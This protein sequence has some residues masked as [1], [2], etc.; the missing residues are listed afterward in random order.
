MDAR[1][2]IYT[3]ATAHLDTSW[4][5][6]LEQ[7][8]EEYI[9][10]TLEENFA[11]FEKFPEYV[12]SFEGAYRYELMEEYYPALFARL[13][14]YAAAGRWRVAG[15][16]YE[17]GDVNIPAPEAL[18]RNFLLGQRYFRETFGQDSR[19]VFLPDCFGFG[20]ALPT[21]AA[22]ANLLGFT[23]Q[24]LEWGGAH[25]APFALGRW[26]GPDG[27]G[28]F[29]APDGHNYAAS[30]T[31]IRSRG[32]LRRALAFLRRRESFPAALIL[33]GV[34]DQGG[35][36]KEASVIRVAEEAE[37]NDLYDVQVLSAGSDQIFRDLAA[38]PRAQ[39]DALPR[40]DG[41][42]L[43]TNHGSGCYTARTLSKRWNRQAEQL[44]DAAERAC[45][46]ARFLGWERYPQRALRAAWKR[47][48][49]HQFHD[50]MTGTSNEANYRRNWNDLMLSQQ[51]FA[52]EYRA[53]VSAVCGGMDM[54][55]AVGHC[56]AVANPL[57]W[58]RT[59]A[60]AVDLPELLR[61][62]P[63]C[64]WDAAGREYPAQ[65]SADGT[66]AVFL[67]AVPG[68][69]V[70]LFDLQRTDPLHAPASWTDRLRAGLDLT[71]QEHAL[72]NKRLRVTIND[73]GDI[74]S[75][76]DKT[77][78]TEMLKKPVRLALF[79]FDGSAVWPAWE[80]DYRELCRRPEYPGSPRI[81]LLE[82]GPAR[83]AVEVTRTARGSTFR[84]V[85]SL[86]AGASFVRVENDVFWRSPRTLLKVELCSAAAARE[87]AYDLGCGVIRRGT[88][89]RRQ[90]EVPAQQWA[91]LSDGARGFGLTALS[92]SRTGW[93]HPDPHTLRLTGVY[94]P[95][96]GCRGN[97]QLLDFGRN[98][99][100]FGLFPHKGGWENGAV[101]AG[102]CFGQ[103]LAAFYPPP[104]PK[105]AGTE[106]AGAATLR[107]AQ[108]SPGV[109]VRGMKLAEDADPRD[110][111]AEVIVR[112]QEANGR[113]MPEAELRLGGGITCVR[114]VYA[115][116]TDRENQAALYL[117]KGALRA[118]F[119]PFALR[120]FAVRAAAVDRAVPPAGQIQIPLPF[121]ASC[122]SFHSA[123][124]P[125]GPE[126]Q[127]RPARRLQSLTH[128]LPGEQFPAEVTCGGVT[129]VLGD[130]AGKNL[131][132]G[133]WRSRVLLPPG[134]ELHLLAACG[135]RELEAPL[136]LDNLEVRVKVP[137][138]MAPVAGGDL[139]SFGES[140][141]VRTFES[142]AP[143]LVFTHR[144]QW[145]DGA[146]RD[147]PAA[148]TVFYHLT[149][150][151][152]GK[153]CVLTLPEDGEFSLLAATVTEEPSARRGSPLTDE[154]ACLP[155]E[156]VTDPLTPRQQKDAR[157][158]GPLR[159]MKHKL[160]FLD[161][162]ARH[163]LHL[164]WQQ[165]RG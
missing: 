129:F 146:W 79:D 28:I 111:D 53:G 117:W 152:P 162:A 58:S 40:W 6:P 159:E 8:I 157:R 78:G 163:R 13:K 107:F 7:T 45:L 85:I 127:L 65:L 67:A 112:L 51:Q 95:L 86:D 57:Q 164:F 116:E 60:V 44:A 83:G 69:A 113:E 131:L 108:L 9:P 63:V 70:R 153:E 96:S 18:L 36:P 134:R 55:F 5:W 155:A 103:P 147:E 89:T 100:A 138:A 161:G 145:K 125:T 150:P 29:A 71:A 156:E 109:I 80:L 149:V 72:E 93:D 39:R 34:G 66:Q 99:F 31:K 75:L 139:F 151:L 24:K 92:D 90:Y 121:Q 32:D 46:F 98:R 105:S 27:E 61:G 119:S 136:F 1:S 94:T 49:A 41:E 33:H 82:A 137:H 74:A 110:P 165:S 25:P 130:A 128:R 20:W 2:R 114:E 16:A 106:A 126:E 144:H 48:I 133:G 3:V 26:T 87:A 148:Q 59:E 97:A 154:M 101:M 50:D 104:A 14:E 81:R 123:E 11:L 37:N 140:G 124:P 52:E 12:F 21:L 91:D 158:K 118:S 22:H 77:L 54:S 47:V 132:C 19:D 4:H 68:F 35:A 88:N 76:F 38:A 142:A 160:K 64:V 42:L 84:Q 62:R 102:A 10:R 115:D 56:V 23:T 73:E 15:S 135:T 30:L 143:A 43:L 141:F 120:T 122:T 17:N